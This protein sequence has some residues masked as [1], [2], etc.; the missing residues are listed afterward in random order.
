MITPA[1]KFKML[2]TVITKGGT[3]ATVVGQMLYRDGWVY[4]LRRRGGMRRFRAPEWELR[5]EGL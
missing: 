1:A 5:K 2:D 4:T 3:K